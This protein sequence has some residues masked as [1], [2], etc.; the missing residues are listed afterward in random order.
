MEITASN[1]LIQGLVIST[2]GFVVILFVFT[3]IPF[4][5]TEDAPVVQKRAAPPVNNVAPPATSQPP[6][7]QPGTTEAGEDLID[8]LQIGEAKEADP[9]ENPLDNQFNDLLK[10]IK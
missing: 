2:I 10:D 8:K 5:M 3:V 1:G 7:E 6:A 9:A 4:F